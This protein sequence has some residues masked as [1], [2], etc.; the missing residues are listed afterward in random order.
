[1]LFKTKQIK[2]K[3]DKKLRQKNEF[4]QEP[5]NEVFY[6]TSFAKKS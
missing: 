2:R 1:M 4:I 3:S 6:S 5:C